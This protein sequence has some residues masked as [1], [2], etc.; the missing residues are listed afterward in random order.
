MD[1]SIAKLSSDA[2]RQKIE[3]V[4]QRTLL[5]FIGRSMADALS[6]HIVFPV[7]YTPLSNPA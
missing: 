3:S 5:F 2:S 1:H 6:S 4:E 7:H